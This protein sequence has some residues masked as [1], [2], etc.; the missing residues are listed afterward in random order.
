MECYLYWKSTNIREYVT[1]SLSN[2][3]LSSNLCN[4]H[5]LSLNNYAKS[6]VNVLSIIALKYA[7][8]DSLLHTTKIASF[9]TINSNFMIKSTVKCGHGL[10]S[11]LFAINFSTSIFVLFFIL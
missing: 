7:I 2:I 9:S 6:F 11:T 4:F 5:T 1:R 10:S 8:L 3:T